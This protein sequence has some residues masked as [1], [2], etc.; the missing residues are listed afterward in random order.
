MNYNIINN[1]M[2]AMLMANNYAISQIFGF[3]FIPKNSTEMTRKI[4]ESYVL[5]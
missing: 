2:L 5:E 3:F 4:I 1:K